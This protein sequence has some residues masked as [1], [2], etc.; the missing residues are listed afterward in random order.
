MVTRRHFMAGSAALT[1]LAASGAGALTPAQAQG[2]A[3]L[4]GWPNRPVRSIVPSG[5]GGPGENY[6]LYTDHFR[7]VFGQAFLLE[8]QPGAAGAIGSLNVARAAPDGYTLLCAANSHVILAPLVAPKLTFDVR[9]DF[10]PIGTIMTYPFC[11]IVN[12]ELPVKTLPEL[13][14]YAKARPGQLNFGSIGVGTGG[15]LVAELFCKRAGIQAVH[16]PYNSAPA[17]VMGVVS[18]QL[19]FTVDTIGNSRGATDSGKVRQIAVTGARRAAAAPHLPTFAEAGLEGFDLLLW[20]GLL[21]PAGTPAP[22]VE[23]I[24]REIARCSGKPSVKERLQQ[25][26]YEPS[27]GSPADFAALIHKELGVWGAVVKELGVKLPG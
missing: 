13:I 20:L 8:N 18:G 6:R 16:I 17:Q 11:L 1:G 26:A 25:A 12:A 14:A 24:N 22:I 5:A 23:A 3:N 4:G 10:V 19:Q 7:E 15:H 9:K 2:A 27:I 21:G